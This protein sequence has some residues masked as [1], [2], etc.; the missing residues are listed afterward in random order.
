MK[1][2]NTALREAT[3][4]ADEALEFTID[5]EDMR[6]YRPTDGQI[7]ITMAAMSRHT[8]DQTKMAAAID[9]FIEVLDEDSAAYVTERLMTRGDP[10][11]LD[12]VEAILR[13]LVEEWVGRPI[14]PPSASTQSRSSGG[15][16]SKPRTT[17]STSSASA[18]ASS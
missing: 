12:E 7:A 10:F 4:D 17:K 5:G 8:S 16:R 1:E 2:F 14:Q 3:E 9:F 18:R 11:G 6:A 15:Q 13:W